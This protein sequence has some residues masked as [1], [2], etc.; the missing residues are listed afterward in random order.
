MRGISQ[1]AE[2]YPSGWAG[3]AERW[4]RLRSELSLQHIEA[5]LLAPRSTLVHAAPLPLTQPPRELQTWPQGAIFGLSA[6]KLFALE[7]R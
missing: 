3:Y 7:A 5:P 6:K 2:G 1:G 4:A